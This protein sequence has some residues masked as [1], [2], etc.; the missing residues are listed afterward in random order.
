MDKQLDCNGW[1]LLHDAALCNCRDVIEVLFRQ[2]AVSS[3][4]HKYYKPIDYALEQ[5]K[6]NSLY[7][8]N[9]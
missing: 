4:D 8:G 1:T 2:R 9:I 5:N 6:K 3:S 7:P